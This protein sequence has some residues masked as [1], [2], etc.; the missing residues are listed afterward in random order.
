MAMLGQIGKAIDQLSAVRALL[1]RNPD[2]LE[3]LAKC[4]DAAFGAYW[5]LVEGIG[6][7]KGENGEA[8][9]DS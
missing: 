6:S 9:I 1:V 3:K 5:R 8:R 2:G 4:N 7:R